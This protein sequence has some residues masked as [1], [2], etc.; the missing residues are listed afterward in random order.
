MGKLVIDGARMNELLRSPAGPV[1]RYMIGRAEVV[2]QG[3]RAKA[4]RLTGC[5]QDSIVKRV[6]EDPLFGFKI[7][8]VSDTTPCSPTRTSYS[9]YVHE[10][11]VQHV[12]AAKGKALAF[13]WSGGPE[14]AG[15][16][17]FQQ[18]NHPG[19]WAQPFLRD[20]LPLAL[21]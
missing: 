2:K 21:A 11:T 3:A 17:F 1:G 10:G 19:T 14:G 15:T 8:I 4:P 20:A 18:V 16:Y 5:L 13:H 6:E 7:T 9:L 12:I